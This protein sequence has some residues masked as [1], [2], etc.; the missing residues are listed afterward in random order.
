MALQQKV[1][2]AKVWAIAK[3]LT[4]V[5]NLVVTICVMNQF[6]ITNSY[7]MF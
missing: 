4:H 2:K 5:L 3:A 7:L 1:P 6:R